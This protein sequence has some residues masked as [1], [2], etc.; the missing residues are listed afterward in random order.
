VIDACSPLAIVGDG[1]AEHLWKLY[2]RAFAP[3]ETLTAMRQTLHRDEFLDQM[4][5][6]RIW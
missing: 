3:L 2:E 5:D 4:R 6:P 1:A